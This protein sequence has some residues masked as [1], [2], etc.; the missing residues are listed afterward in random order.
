[1]HAN[2]SYLIDVDPLRD[3]N[4]PKFIILENALHGPTS[5]GD[6]PLSG[7]ILNSDPGLIGVE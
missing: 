6:R 4:T 1:L 2:K 3:S 7:K 5:E